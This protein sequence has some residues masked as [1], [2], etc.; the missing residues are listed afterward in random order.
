MTVEQPCS[1][2]F[3]HPLLTFPHPLILHPSHDSINKTSPLIRMAAGANATIYPLEGNSLTVPHRSAAGNKTSI[4][5]TG[6]ATR[7]R[8]KSFL[9]NYYGIQ[10]TDATNQDGSKDS[11]SA[12]SG[13]TSKTDPYDLGTTLSLGHLSDDQ[14]EMTLKLTLLVIPSVYSCFYRQ[15]CV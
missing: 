2:F 8:A 15:S 11:S 3:S 9:R 12:P 1:F 5:A 6:T 13:P 14:L 7:R 4:T 10:Q